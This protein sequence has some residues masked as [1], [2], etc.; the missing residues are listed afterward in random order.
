MSLVGV[1]TSD[2]GSIHNEQATYDEGIARAGDQV[3]VQSVGEGN[4]LY[5]DHDRTWLLLLLLDVPCLL[6]LLWWLKVKR[7]R[8]PR[9]RQTP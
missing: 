2:D 6:Y 3:R 9:A 5:D 1:F 7:W 8:G 4:D